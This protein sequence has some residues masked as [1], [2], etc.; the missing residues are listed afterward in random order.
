MALMD[1]VR[2]EAAAA[3]A[4]GIVAV[5]NHGRRRGG[6]MPLW[7]GEGDLPTPEFIRDAARKGLEDGET[8]YTW[9]A[10]IPELREALTRYHERHFPGSFAPERFYITGSGMQSIQLAIQATVGAGEEAVYLSPA[11]PNFPACLGVAGGTPVPVRLDFG[12]AGWTLDVDKVKRAITSKTRALFINT[13][14]NPTGWTADLATLRELLGLAR[15]HGLWIIADEIYT[16][17]HYAGSRAPSFMDI[18][19]PDDRIIFV[20]SFSKNWAMTGWRIGWMTVN[21]ELGPMVE[22]LIQ[23]STSGV[24]QFMQRGAV[25]A[26]DHG[27]AFIRS[28]V[29]RAHRSRD[30]LCRKLAD[31]G[32]VRLSPPEGAFYLFFGVDG[33][34][35]SFSAAFDIVDNAGVGLAPGTA[36]GEGGEAFFRLC[37]HRP[38][39]QVGEAADRLA[40]WLRGA[41]AKSA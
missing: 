32:R 23:Y 1:D 3:P 30:A 7:A 14:S 29:D 9:Q 17:F 33:I 5:M 38:V 4:S 16:H 25:A 41:V 18:M 22:N 36:F 24:A 2:R 34:T 6:V 35:D 12:N 28:Q 19:E 11:W 26:L 20:N 10:G 40:D 39:D 27:D 13:P 37:F 15:A 8:F 21:P 31:T